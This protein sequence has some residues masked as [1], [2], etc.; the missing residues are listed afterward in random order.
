MAKIT[1]K[2]RF[3]FIVIESTTLTPRQ[4]A[5]VGTMEAVLKKSIQNGHGH[6]P[7]AVA[8]AVGVERTKDAGKV[9]PG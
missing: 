9:K 3:P 4:Q 8:V 2:I 1:F 6:D 7:R 5:S